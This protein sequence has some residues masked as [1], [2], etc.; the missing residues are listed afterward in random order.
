MVKQDPRSRLGKALQR[1]LQALLRR[2]ARILA[3][4][5]V[6]PQR[7][8]RWSIDPHEFDQHMASL[9]ASGAVVVDLHELTARMHRGQ[10]LGKLVAV[11]FDDGY[12]DFLEHA[13]PIL[14]EYDLP[15]TVF[16]PVAAI[17]EYST[18]SQIKPDAPIMSLRE[19]EQVQ[20]LGFSLGSHSLTHPRLSTLSAG[21]LSQ[22][23]TGARDY[24]QEAFGLG[25]MPF[26]YPFGD[27]GQREQL[28]AQQAGYEC[29]VGF[30]G[31]WGNGF[32][33]DRFALNRDAITRSCNQRV[34][35]ATLRGWNDC[36]SAARITIFQ[37]G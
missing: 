2:R 6:S 21:D 29:A 18:W 9:R 20:H 37:R 11:T 24:L 35:R 1:G 36:L 33:T 3:Y 12:R 22:E 14:R 5:S 4:H 17:G 27:F 10:D 7:T 16:V 15:A 31:L 25:A 30:G 23:L 19:L 34:F 13:A 26:A 32:E 8:D 28:A